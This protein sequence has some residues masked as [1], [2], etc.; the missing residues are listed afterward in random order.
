MKKV[1][2]KD[3]RVKVLGQYI[4]RKTKYELQLHIHTLNSDFRV[5]KQSMFMSVILLGVDDFAAH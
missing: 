3:D 4:I 5:D 1:V 2:G